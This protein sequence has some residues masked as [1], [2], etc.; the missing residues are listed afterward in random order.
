VNGDVHG[1]H[2]SCGSVT[3][4][5]RFLIGSP[6]SPASAGGRYLYPLALT[7]E[8]GRHEVRVRVQPGA[9]I[10]GYGI[11]VKGH[12][13]VPGRKAVGGSAPGIVM[14]LQVVTDLKE[15]PAGLAGAL[16]HPGAARVERPDPVD[17]AVGSHMSVPADDDVGGAS[18]QQAAELLV[19]KAGFDPE[20]VVGAWRTRGTI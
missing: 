13:P 1:G 8:D 15:E 12:D 7:R 4:A 5:S 11:G 3:H 14:M 17:E 10:T 9:E 2:A 18:R 16:G 20:A 6:A 19:R